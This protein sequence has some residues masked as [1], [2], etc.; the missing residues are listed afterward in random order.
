MYVIPFSNADKTFK[1]AIEDD[2]TKSFEDAIEK[3][4]LDENKIKEL[5]SLAVKKESVEV[6][7]VSQFISCKLGQEMLIELNSFMFIFQ[8]YFMN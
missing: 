2:N 7:K 8:T 5:I 1:K 6:L 3:F 4:S